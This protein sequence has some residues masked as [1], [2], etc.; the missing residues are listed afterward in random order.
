LPSFGLGP[1]GCHK[2]GLGPT[3]CHKSGL[4][5]TDFLKTLY[6]YDY[7]IRCEIKA[8]VPVLVNYR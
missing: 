2:S 1:T 6:E 8:E 7:T 4:G 3:G 5:P